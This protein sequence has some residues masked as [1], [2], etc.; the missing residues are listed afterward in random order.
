MDIKEAK[1]KAA[2]I[3]DA[4]ENLNRLLSDASSIGLDAEIYMRT[5][6]RFGGK[7]RRFI[8]VKCFIFIDQSAPS[9]A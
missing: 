4:A 2:E 1:K 8:V 7:Q 6:A 5:I 3:K 9:P